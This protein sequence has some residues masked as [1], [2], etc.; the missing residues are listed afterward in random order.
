[1][2]EEKGRLRQG[3]DVVSHLSYL[4]LPNKQMFETMRLYGIGTE[5]ATRALI[6]SK[7]FQRETNGSSMIQA[8]QQL[9]SNISLN[10]IMYES[11]SSVDDASD[12]E[13]ESLAIPSNLR[14]NPMA[15]LHTQQ[16]QISASLSG[17]KRKINE[18]TRERAAKKATTTTTTLD[19]TKPSGMRKADAADTNEK[20][21]SRP[22]AD[23]MTEV[24][25]AKMTASILPTAAAATTTSRKRHVRSGSPEHALTSEGA[26][27]ASGTTIPSEQRE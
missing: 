11:D 22:R 16:H 17:K 20:P 1:M 13:E 19:D 5:E 25:D 10:N 24:V 12:D 27:V 9:V 8:I 7:A 15:N 3:T 14:I 18:A 21:T 26:V 4:S 23:S 2:V 6:I